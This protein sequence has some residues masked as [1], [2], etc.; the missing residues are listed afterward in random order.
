MTEFSFS[1]PIPS[2]GIEYKGSLKSIDQ[3][4]NL[5]ILNTEDRTM[6]D[7]AGPPRDPMGSPV[8]EKNSTYFGSWS[9]LVMFEAAQFR[10]GVLMW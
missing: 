4:M 6:P 8:A 10:G 7:H 1:W 3:Y 5:Q 9:M 2:R